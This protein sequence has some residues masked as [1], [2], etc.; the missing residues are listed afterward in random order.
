VLKSG[1]SKSYNSRLFERKDQ[2]RRLKD[3][4]LYLPSMKNDLRFPF[5]KIY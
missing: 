2:L 5:F 4:R 1:L 3:D